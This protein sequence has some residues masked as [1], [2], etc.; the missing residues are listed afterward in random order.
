MLW[1]EMIFLAVLLLSATTKADLPVYT[2]ASNF[3]QLT[4]HHNGFPRQEYRS[5]EILG[6]VFQVGAWNLTGADDSRFIFIGSVYGEGKAGP[7]ILDARD[8][9]LVHADQQYA[10]TYHSDVQYINGQPYYMFWQGAHGRGHANGH[11]LFIDETYNLVYN[12][13]AQGRPGVLADMHDLRVTHDGNAIFTTYFNV[14]WDTSALGGEQ[15]SLIMDSGFQEVN[16]ETNEIV[17]DWAASDH[18]NIADS[19]A[20]YGEGYGIGPE[21]GYDFA[22]VNSVEKVIYRQYKFW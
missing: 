7:M 5:S 9:S 14:P 16:I 20:P 15:E 17:F 11:C 22:H 1:T 3:K 4:N 18:F 8:L 6:P 12:V 10:N 21:S 2:D 19:K 13:T